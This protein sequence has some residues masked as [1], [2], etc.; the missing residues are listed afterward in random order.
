MNSTSIAFGFLILVSGLVWAGMANNNPEWTG[1]K[2][3]CVG[4]CYEAFK[5]ESGGSIA[6]VETA[7]QVAMAAA[8]PEALGQKY[9]GQCVACHG[10][11]GGGGIGP[12]LAGQSADDLIGKLTAYR[13][14]EQRGAQSALMWPV[15]KPMSDK[16]IANLAT[17]IVTL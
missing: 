13:A 15:A 11:E 12:M 10:N 5:A 9:Y 17:Y 3:R 16:D 6:D 1:N 14:G 2:N 7:K 4:E 8:S